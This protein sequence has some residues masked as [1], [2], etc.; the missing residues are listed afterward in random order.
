MNITDFLL[1]RIAE[2]EEAAREAVALRAHMALDPGPNADVGW[3]HT[4]DGPAV[5][6]GPE[7]MMAECEAK[8]RIVEDYDALNADYSVTRE[9][10]TEARRYQALVS[11]AQLATAYDDHP[12]YDEAWRC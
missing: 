4:A 2:D 5:I 6:V 12:D 1:A 10:Q 9:S 8:R 7:W 11:V 3:D